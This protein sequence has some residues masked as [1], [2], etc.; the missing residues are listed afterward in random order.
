M[1][2]MDNQMVA[3]TLVL[4]E[5]HSGLKQKNKNFKN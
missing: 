5:K 3:S 2:E 4:N 1:V